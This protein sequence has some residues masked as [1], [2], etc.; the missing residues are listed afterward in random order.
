MS[1]PPDPLP[2][3]V[4]LDTSVWRSQH[5]LWSRLGAALLHHLRSHG[6]RLALPEVVEE[7]TRALAEK[8]ALQAFDKIEENARY[9]RHFSGYD[10]RASLPERYALPSGLGTVMNEIHDILLRIPIALE[11]VHAAL[12]K[13]I[14]RVPPNNRK[15][16]DGRY[17][18]QF[19]DTLIW[20]AAVSLT[21]DHTV[22][23][24]VED[25]AFF[26]PDNGGKHVARELADTLPSECCLT[27][28]ST[29]LDCLVGLGAME[30]MSDPERKEIITQITEWIHRCVQRHFANN[31]D[32]IYTSHLPAEG[33]IFRS[34]EPSDMEIG[35]DLRFGLEGFRNCPGSLKIRGDGLRENTGVRYINLTEIEIRWTEG[36]S[37]PFEDRVAEFK[38]R[39]GEEFLITIDIAPF[40]EAEDEVKKLLAEY[41]IAYQFSEGFDWGRWFGWSIRGKVPEID[42]WVA[43]LSKMEQLWYRSLTVEGPIPWRW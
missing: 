10:I 31:D 40:E 35:V 9:L 32:A 12:R 7:E 23:F 37:Y 8:E 27:V 19:R 14:D 41:G 38:K 39:E 26:E 34:R 13:V 15:D 18:E 28:H 25:G 1:S 36:T 29:L 33:Q 6:M 16:K 11:H 30:P 5:L 43:L 21:R 4:V 2:I 17:R 3:L 20:E 42:T 24:V 22:H